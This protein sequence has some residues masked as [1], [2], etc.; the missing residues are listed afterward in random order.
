MFI[1]E[2]LSNHISAIVLPGSK[3]SA[4]RPSESTVQLKMC[5]CSLKSM[6]MK[7]C[8]NQSDFELAVP[9]PS[10][11]LTIASA[12]SHPLIGRS[13][14]V[15]VKASKQRHCKSFLFSQYYFCFCICC[16]QCI[17]VDFQCI[18]KNIHLL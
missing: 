5:C 11:R 1:L 9:G 14:S 16:V 7:L 13:E 6:A 18:L 15:L 17:I 4:L 12:F 10:S 8:F 2:L 3:K